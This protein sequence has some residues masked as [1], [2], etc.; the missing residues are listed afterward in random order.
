M[1]VKFRC[2]ISGNVF[3]YTNPF[4]IEDMRAHPQYEEV[5]EQEEIVQKRT[6]SKKK[7]KGEKS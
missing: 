3:E 7:A 6:S 4:D 2:L 5:E 1:S